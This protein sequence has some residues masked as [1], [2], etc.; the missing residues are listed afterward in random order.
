MTIVQG[1]RKKA[2][3]KGRKWLLPLCA[4]MMGCS[5]S[6]EIPPKPVVAVKVAHVQTQ[7]VQLS[8]TAPATI[9]P[10]EQ[11]SIAAR[12]T[13][14]IRSLRV[15]KGDSV[16]AGDVLATLES[17]DMAA[18]RGEAA[19]A[20]TDAEA[21]LQ[22]TSAGTLPTD[23]ERG[24]GQLASAEAALNQAQKIYDRRS[25]LFKL[26]AI[27]GRDLLI[28][29]TDLAKA[30]A[31]YDVAKKSLDL[32]KTQSGEKDIAIARAHVEQAKA[33][34]AQAD[35]QLAFTDLRSPLSGTVTDQFQYAGDMGQPGTPT[36]IVMDL[37]V[38][39]ARAQVPESQVGQIKIGEDC[40]FTSSDATVSAGSGRVTVVNKA[41]DAARRTVEVWCEIQN[42]SAAI[43][44]GVFGQATFVTGKV[45]AAVVVP[46][47]AVQFKEGTRTGTVM[48]VDAQNVAH[49]REVQGGETVGDVVRILEGVKPGETV[50]TEG[51]YSLPDGAQVKTGEAGKEGGKAAGKGEKAEKD[52]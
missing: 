50:V 40:S 17:R 11:A 42:Q 29:Q 5:H 26:G 22:K 24:R 36:F 37:S 1:N 31:D 45:P 7:D 35:A 16:R 39:T 13:A 23:I 48:V 34:L 21:N 27:P 43:R 30:Q 52:P 33:H 18:A 47:A 9:F 8:I 25:E 3:G 38:V 49:Q 44:G 15:H 19:A 32:L 12:I 41:V 6:E 51:S 28:S 46:L 2:R 14:P 10:R 20:L 4:V